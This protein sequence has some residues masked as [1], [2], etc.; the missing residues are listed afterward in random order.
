MERILILYQLPILTMISMWMDRMPIAAASSN[1][2]S[3]ALESARLF[4]FG[5]IFVS[6]IDFE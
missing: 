6:F 2:I 4:V 3:K 1:P 5:K